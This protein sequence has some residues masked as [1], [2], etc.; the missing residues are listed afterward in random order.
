MSDTTKS[1]AIKFVGSSR[2]TETLKILP[3]TTV[4][5]VLRKLDLGPGY[6]LSDAQNRD[7]V[8]HAGDVL[9][10]RVEDGDLLYASS[11]VDAGT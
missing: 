6:E 5:E 3:G 9:Y 2:A 11:L 1:I 8:F 4:A 7:V 10:A